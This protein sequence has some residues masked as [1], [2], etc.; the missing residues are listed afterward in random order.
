[1]LSRSYK[2]E[3]LMQMLAGIH[4]PRQLNNENEAQ[5]IIAPLKFSL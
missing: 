5:Y 1:M 4:F 2:G 3:R